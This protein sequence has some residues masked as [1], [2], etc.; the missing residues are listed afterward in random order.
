[1][2]GRRVFDAYSPPKE[3]S[4]VSLSIKLAAVQAS[5]SADPPAAEQRTTYL[6]M[7][8]THPATRHE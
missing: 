1:M 3:G 8:E 6:Q 2:H 5:G 4:L 7:L